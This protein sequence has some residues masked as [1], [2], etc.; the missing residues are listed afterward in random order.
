MFLAS[1]S[2]FWWPNIW[3]QMGF[4]ELFDKTIGS[5]HF[6]PG[7]YLYGISFLT[8]IH[9]R[10]PSLIF[11]HWW[12]NIWPNMGFPELKK[13]NKKKLLVQ[14]ISYLVFTLRGKFLYPYSFWCS[15]PHFRRSGGQIF[16]RIWGFQN[17]LTKLLVQFISYLVFTLYWISFLTPIH[18]RVPSLIFDLWWP[19]IWPKM[20]FPEFFEKNY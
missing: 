10:V 13:Q 4:P 7:I 19:N 17:F 1:F 12:P 16:G 11:D 5:I 3:S 18:F 2:A 14:L 15:W 9:F 8:P 20:G 6:I